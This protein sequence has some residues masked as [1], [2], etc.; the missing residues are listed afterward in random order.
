MRTEEDKIVQSG[1]TV[2]LG[3]REYS[4]APLVIKESREWRKKVVGLISEMP[5]YAEV[6]TDTPDEF[7]DALN[8]IL[9]AMPDKVADLFFKYAVNLNREEIEANATDAE[10]AK[11]FEQVIEIAF[12][13]AQSLTQTMKH[14]SQ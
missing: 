6:T 14:L 9:V 5:K 13:L 4:I 1:I 12:P 3:G 7:G 2:I 11:A 8:A 10:L